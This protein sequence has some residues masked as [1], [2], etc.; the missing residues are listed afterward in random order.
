M[1]IPNPGIP[2]GC[3]FWVCR[4]DFIFWEE[5]W[6]MSLDP[7]GVLYLCWAVCFYFLGIFHIPR[8]GCSSFTPQLLHQHQLRPMI[9]AGPGLVSSKGIECKWLWWCRNSSCGFCIRAV[10]F[11]FFFFQ[12]PSL[13]VSMECAFITRDLRAEGV[14]RHIGWSLAKGLGLYLHHGSRLPQLFF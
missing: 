6:L 12:R 8:V 2:S 9:Q 4:Y 10:R 5:A 13:S 14:R 3:V 7:L 11:F 1:V